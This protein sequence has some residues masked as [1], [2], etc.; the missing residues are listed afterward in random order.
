MLTGGIGMGFTWNMNVE[1]GI[2][3]TKY[4]TMY[5]VQGHMKLHET[6]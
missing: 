1:K 5:S 2:Q 3:N 6:H 4:D